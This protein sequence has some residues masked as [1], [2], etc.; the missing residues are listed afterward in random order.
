MIRCI[1]ISLLVALAAP[2]WAQGR[3]LFGAS[4]GSTTRVQTYCC[5]LGDVDA[6][7]KPRTWPVSSVDVKGRRMVPNDF[8]VLLKTLVM[9][10]LMSARPFL[11][12]LRPGIAASLAELGVDAGGV[13]TF[14]SLE[15]AIACANR[16]PTPDRP[17]PARVS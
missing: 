3:D 1:I 7:G 5:D 9:A 2:A 13:T 15:H 14:P 11:V 17:E 12:G 4:D 6:G 16:E 8:T 10:R